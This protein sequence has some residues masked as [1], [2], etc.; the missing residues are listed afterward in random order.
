MT[1]PAEA[2]NVTEFTPEATETEDGTVSSE[3]SL[4]SDTTAPPAE[5]GCE[6]VTV[7]EVEESDCSDFA[8]Q[9]TEPT[10][11]CVA[12]ESVAVTELPL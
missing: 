10:T 1:V 5:A 12:S 9:F 4:A 2:V 11:V 3:L 8:K 6:R 7:H